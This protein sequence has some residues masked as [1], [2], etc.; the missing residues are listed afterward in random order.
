MDASTG[1]RDALH[2]GDILEPLGELQFRPVV[3]A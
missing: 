1:S 2:A 3:D